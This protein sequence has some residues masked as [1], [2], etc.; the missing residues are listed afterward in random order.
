[1]EIA[2]RR[3]ASI[4]APQSQVY[5]RRSSIAELANLQSRLASFSRLFVGSNRKISVKHL[6]AYIQGTQFKR[7]TIERN[8]AVASAGLS[9]RIGTVC[10]NTASDAAVPTKSASRTKFAFMSGSFAKYRWNVRPLSGSRHFTAPH[11]S[12]F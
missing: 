9:C 7:S 8:T 6:D 12:L 2:D 11:E 1:M 3:L 5:N 4:T 10:W